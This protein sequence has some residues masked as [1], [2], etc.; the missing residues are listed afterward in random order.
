MSLF[1]FWVVS[2]YGLLGRYKIFGGTYCLSLQC[3]VIQFDSALY[4]NVLTQQLQ[5]PSAQN[6]IIIIFMFTYVTVSIVSSDSD[7]DTH[8]P[9]HDIDT[10][11]SSV[12]FSL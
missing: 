4:F 2:P 7:E 6:I 9:D 3:F 5:E 11:Y 10:V 8:C 1:V 12:F